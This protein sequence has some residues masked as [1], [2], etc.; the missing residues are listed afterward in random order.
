MNKMSDYL[1]IKEAAAYLGVSRNTL[2]QWEKAKKI[3][4]YRW[5]QNN[6]RGYKKEDLDQVLEQMANSCIYK[7]NTKKNNG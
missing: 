6:W 5:P 7:S 4:A 2:R 3:K 1:R